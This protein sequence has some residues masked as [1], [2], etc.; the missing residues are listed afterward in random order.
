MAQSVRNKIL[1]SLIIS[2]YQIKGIS[3]RGRHSTLFATAQINQET[4]HTFW[5]PC[6]VVSRSSLKC[7][8]HS[9]RASAKHT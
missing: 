5:L 7:M 6:V 9:V 2:Y 4:L 1:Q 8:N 3:E